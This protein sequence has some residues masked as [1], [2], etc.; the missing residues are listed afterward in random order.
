MPT[1]RNLEFISREEAIRR[2]PEPKT[3]VISINNVNDVPAPL[4]PGWMAVHVVKYN[5]NERPGP[6]SFTREM[7]R[8]IVNFVTT[9]EERATKVLIHC[10]AGE[11]RSAT[12]AL[13]LDEKYNLGLYGGQCAGFTHTLTL[14][15][16]FEIIL[17][18]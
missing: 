8:D 9:H 11:S 4:R 16:L 7:A 12:V 6:G 3:I 14:D 13:A 18:V 5:S 2:Q 1:I 10:F 17:D 15:F